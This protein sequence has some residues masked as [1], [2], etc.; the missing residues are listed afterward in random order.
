MN[1][2][3]VMNQLSTIEV[4]LSC[5]WRIV[6]AILAAVATVQPAAAQSTLRV[7][8]AAGRPV[9][10]TTTATSASRTSTENEIRIVTNA[11]RPGGSISQ[12]QIPSSSADDISAQLS[13]SAR[14]AVATP[15]VQAPDV[16]NLPSPIVTDVAPEA[17][18]LFSQ[19]FTAASNNPQQP[20]ADN[21][22]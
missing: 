9:D 15:V 12:R 2:V 17:A 14:S 22:H 7:A 11:S 16:A 10:R 1:V 19:L 5:R 21:S 20:V 13:H 18:D 3:T 8:S 4:G 6:V